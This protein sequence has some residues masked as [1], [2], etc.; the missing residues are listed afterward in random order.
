MMPSSLVGVGCELLSTAGHAG[1]VLLPKDAP[2]HAGQRIWVPLRFLEGPASARATPIDRE[3][4]K[5]AQGGEKDGIKTTIEIQRGPRR[6]GFVDE[7]FD[8]LETALERNRNSGTEVCE[9]DGTMVDELFPETAAERAAKVRGYLV[10]QIERCEKAVETAVD[11]Q[12]AARDRLADFEAAVAAGTAGADP[13]T[14][15]VLAD[16]PFAGK[17]RMGEAGPR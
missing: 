9:G 1:L 6:G 12:I 2:C 13:Q 7:V 14:G 15:E 8:E 16:D 17:V 10:D 3:L 5:L 4:R 11:K